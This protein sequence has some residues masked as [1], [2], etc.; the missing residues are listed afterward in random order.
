MPAVIFADGTRVAGPTYRAIERELRRDPW[1]P[2]WPLAFREEMARRA[3]AWSGS[4]I[5]TRGTSRVFLREL[6]NA[7]LI[8]IEEDS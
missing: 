6:E 7:G 8:R 4:R 2:R 5:R 1:N 3:S